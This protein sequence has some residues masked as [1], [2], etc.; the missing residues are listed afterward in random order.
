MESDNINVS[1]ESN[2]YFLEEFDDCLQIEQLG[3]TDEKK[4][5]QPKKR[6][7]TSKLWTFFERLPEKNSSDGKSKVKCKL[8]GYI[9]NYES[10]Y[11]I[12]NLKRHNDNCV[13]KDTRDIGQ[14]IF[15]KEHNSMLMRSSKFDL[16]KFRELVV[17]AI[18]MHNLPLSFVEYT[19]IKSMLP[20]LREDVVLISRNTVKADIIKYLCLT[21]HFVNKNWVLQ[22]RI[23]NFS[24][25]PPPHN[26]VALSEKIYALLVEWGIESKL[27]S[28][29][30]DNASA[31]DTFV[32]LLKVQL[33]MR[34]QLLGRGK[35]FHIRC[36]AH[37]LN[38]IVQD[39]LKEI[40]SAI[41]KVRESIKYVAG[42][43]GRKQKFLECVSL[44]NLNAKR[45]LKQDVPTRWNST[46]L[47]L[48]SALYFRLTFSHLEISDSNFKHSPS[49]DEWDRIEKL[50]KFLSVFYEITS[51]MFDPWYKI[52]FVEWSYTKLYGSD[53]AEFKKVKDHLFA[54]YDEYAVE[55]PNTPSA[56][57]DTPFDEKNVHK[58]KNEFLKEFDNFQPYVET[59]MNSLTADVINLEI[60]KEEMS[61]VECSNTVDVN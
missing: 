48:E 57:N 51:V 23:L 47:M 11:G 17:A 45:G 12:G 3:A 18:V 52:Q 14:M 9:L 33:I 27:F 46:L 2:V 40:D 42:S 19:G 56:L 49:R 38:L 31:N 4:P 29:T 32:D 25:M 59:D 13:R 43:Q 30:L 22:K 41:Q 53:S 6:K 54:L 58:G 1:F 44:V 34:K 55:V 61:S 20:Y 60:S 15:S 8:C 37:I 10:K 35:F 24:F 5:C 36:C 21:A 28:I 16:E 7:L 50:S 39:G 26:G